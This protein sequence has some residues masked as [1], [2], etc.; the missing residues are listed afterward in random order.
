MIKPKRQ[1]TMLLSYLN[2]DQFY[3]LL[4]IYKSFRKLFIDY[5]N[6]TYHQLFFS[7]F[8]WFLIQ[9]LNKCLVF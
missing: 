9:I 1:I 4:D 2:R 8:L 7:F 6:V 3:N 5:A